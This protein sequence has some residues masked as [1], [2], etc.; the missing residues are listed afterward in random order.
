[1]F[2]KTPKLA[3][4]EKDLDQYYA[5]LRSKLKIALKYVSKLG[6]PKGVV[7]QGDLMYTKAD[8]EIKVI[9]GEK[10]V[11][12]QPNTIAYAIPVKSD[13]GKRILNTKIGVI[14]HTTYSGGPTLADMTASFGADVTSLNRSAAVWFDNATYHDLSGRVKFTLKE[15]QVVT[16]HL[17]KAGKV[18]QKI[19]S[20]EL[21]H[22]LKVQNS[23]G[24]AV[25]A[26]FK[27]FTNTKVRAGVKIDNPRAHT[28]EY[29]RYFEEWWKKQID[30][31]KMEKTKKQKTKLMKEHLKN[32]RQVEK[33]LRQVIEFQGHLVDAKEM[34]IAKLNSGAS[35]MTRTFIKTADG[36][37][38]TPHEGFV[39]IDR[40]SGNAVKLISRLTFSHNN[41]TALKN[42]TK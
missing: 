37:K 25:G 20:K 18:F 24:S 9:D 6:I 38:I 39:A 29:Y 21:A 19:S 31:A 40:L 36:Y 28:R 11:V 7:L 17:S 12:F 42:W 34:I 27:T 41:F 32:L 15:T 33:T 1:V 4:T 16:K 22:F 30:A 3:K 14:W 13:F 5:G 8:Q 23:L 26:S 35:R 10:H 2:N